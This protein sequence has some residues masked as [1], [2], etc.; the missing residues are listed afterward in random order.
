M[1]AIMRRT[2]TVFLLIL[3]PAILAA[4][5]VSEGQRPPKRPQIGYMSLASGLSPRVEAFRQGLR[6]LGHVEGQSITI[7]Y[8]WAQGKQDRLRDLA[9]ELVQLKVDVIVTGG[10]T[11]TRAA[12]EATTAIPI[13]MG[14]DADPVEAGFVASL[15]R[16][17]GNIT[18]T[19]ILSPELSAK[20]LELL[21]EASPGIS[22]VAVFANPDE[23]VTP[24]NLRATQAA[25][26]ALHL[27]LQV[28]EVRG[29]EDWDGAVR[30]A[31]RER[32][33]ALTVFPDYFALFF[34]KRLADLAAKNRLPAVHFAKEFAEAGGLM[35]YGAN[36]RDMH[37]RAATYV[38]KILKGTRPADLPVEQA[39]R[40]ELV[41]NG[42]TAKAL[43]LTIPQS[44]LL[45]ADLVIQ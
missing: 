11:A 10:P 22:R 15:A 37:R 28:L 36:D 41:I 6:D 42:K 16:P 25:A 35:A 9:A 14:F 21:K 3:A 40:F 39:T 4:P 30:A 7:E 1:E 29:L 33:D 20:R 27:Q 17:G 32:A 12:K 44:L 13:V 2:R 19:A 5:L 34:G 24:L 45:R 43:G 23:P 38:D 31:V 18:G 26:R 8:R